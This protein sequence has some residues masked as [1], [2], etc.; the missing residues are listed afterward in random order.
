MKTTATVN[1]TVCVTIAHQWDEEELLGDILRV[2]ENE[3]KVVCIETIQNNKNL[4]LVGDSKVTLITVT[5][6]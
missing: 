6:D 4:R 5:E 3:A 1:V 2:S